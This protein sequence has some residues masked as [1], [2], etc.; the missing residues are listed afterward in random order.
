MSEPITVLIADD[1]AMVRG[2]VRG[3]LETQPD[4]AVVAEAG[5]GEE[6]VELAAEHVPDV[7][8]VDLVMPGIGGVE[9]IRRLTAR[10]PRTR[11]VVLTSYDA[12]AH[13]FPAIRAGAHSYVL[14]DV[15]PEELADVVRKAAAGE[16]VLHPRVAARVVQEMQ[17]ARGERPNAFRE[18]SDR[19]LEVLRLIADGLP[20]VEL[21][22]RLFISEKTVK[23]HVSNILAKLH[24]ADRTQAAV[25]AWRHGVARRD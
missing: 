15:G 10:S 1:H 9:A 11:P 6:A 16:A 21:A 14:K 24:L 5:S 17:G 20:N 22:A 23:S 4:I 2:G 12:D 25:Y 7:A 13:V 18:L 19:E 8:L 3:F